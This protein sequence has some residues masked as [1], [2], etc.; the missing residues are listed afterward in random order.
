M[1]LVIM[2]CLAGGSC[3]PPRCESWEAMEF[4]VAH[5]I[6]LGMWPSHTSFQLTFISEIPVQI[7][8][9]SSGIKIIVFSVT[10]LKILKY[11]SKS[12]L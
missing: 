8:N 12:T 3:E 1:L 2:G 7:E 11:L 10:F 6:K 9:I 4:W 5:G